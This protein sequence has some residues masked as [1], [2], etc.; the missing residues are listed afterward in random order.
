[1]KLMRGGQRIHLY[2]LCWNDA[3]MLPWFFQHYDRIVD[4]YFIFDNGSTDESLSI[5]EKHGRLHL[6]HFDVAGDSFVDEERRMGD[7][8]WRGSDADWVI[9]TDIDE[10]I[11]RPGLRN[12]LQ[13]CTE[14]NVTAI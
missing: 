2:C 8:R 9:V 5:I 11:Y 1:M 3:R 6:A 14:Q 12:Y 7:T 10:H 4:A 13:R